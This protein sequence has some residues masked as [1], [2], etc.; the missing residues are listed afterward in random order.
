MLPY[1]PI[2]AEGFMTGLRGK[3][4]GCGFF[5][6]N[7]LHAW[8]EIEG[9][10]IVAVCDLEK[11]RAQECAREF[12][13][14]AVY[15]DADE[16][17]RTE[18][19]IEEDMVVMG[20]EQVKPK[21]IERWGLFELSLRGPKEGNPCLDVELSAR[22]SHKKRV[23]NPDGFYDGDGIYRI[24]FMPDIP[25]TW[26]STTQRNCGELNGITG[27]FTCV[28]LSPENYG[29]VTVEYTQEPLEGECTVE[30]P[31]KPYMAVQLRKFEADSVLREV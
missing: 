23:V 26:S 25:G 6:S 16:M 7:Y 21:A 14:G 5:A 15:E 17:L 28:E 10:D 19:R 27:S 31:G 2:W 4:I 3:L 20:S 30:L 24:R 13:V 11:A 12:G 8:R 9:A 22:F 29:P 18:P 1:A